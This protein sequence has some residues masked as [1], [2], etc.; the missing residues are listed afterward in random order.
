MARASGPPAGEPLPAATPPRRPGAPGRRSGPR[1]GAGVWLLPPWSRA[2]LL[3]FRAPAVIL[4][5]LGAAAIL[6]CASSSAGLF[7]SSAGAEALHRMAAADCPD[8]TYPTIQGYS[9]EQLTPSVQEQ[10]RGSM[11]G[12]GLPGPYQVLAP[13][14]PIRLTG[15]AASGSAPDAAVNVF[16]RQDAV[17][18]VR[19]LSRGPARGLWLPDSLASSLGVRAGQQLRL[20]KASTIPVAGVYRELSREPVQ[21]YWCSYATLFANTG[22]SIVL[23]PLVLATDIGTVNAVQRAQL[24]G[25]TNYWVSPIDPTRLTL[26]SARALNDKQAAAYRAFGSSP[27]DDLASRLS[28]TGQLPVFT[29][30]AGLIRSGLRAPV[31][32]IALGGTLLALLLIGAAGS[33]WADRRAGEVRLLSAR[34]VG[35]AAL[36]GKAVAE[37]AA[38]AAVGTLLGWLAA[39]WLVRS[40]GPSRYVDPGAPARALLVAGAALVAGLALL[41]LVAGRRARAATEVTIGARRGRLAAVPWELA[42]L[43]AAGGCYLALRR[44]QAVVLT[45][46][47]A[48]VNLLVVTFPL[49][50]MAGSAVL[51][52]RLLVLALPAAL[53]RPARRWPAWY[54]AS[55]RVTAARL[56]TVILLAAATMPIAVG[57]YAAGLTQTTQYTLDSKAR[58]F[59]GGNSSINSVDPLRRT[60]ATDRAGTVVTRYQYASLDGQR[61]IVLAIDPDTFAA[62]TFW[63]RRYADQPLATLL[64]RLRQPSAGGR[65]P[66][67]VVAADAGHTPVQDDQ[68]RITLGHSTEQL[69]VA[70]VPRLFPGRRLPLPMLVVDA[71]RLGQVDPHAGTVNELWTRGPVDPAQAAVVAQGARIFDIADLVTV[72]NVANFLG[73]SWTFGYLSAL[74]ALVGLVAIGGLLLYLETRQRSRIAAYALGRR[75]GLT[76]ATHLRS[77]LAELGT[78]LI[79]ALVLGTGLA[80][81]AVLLVYRQLNVDPDRPPAPLLTV[82]TAALIGAG[83]IVVVITALAAAYAQRAADRTNVAEVL[84]LGA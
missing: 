13:E 52:V 75:M 83:I 69:T 67:L 56:V 73:I 39:G 15:R 43:A 29:E 77:L 68:L 20:G 60:P 21:P 79:T 47:V 26:S 40:L 48:Q 54:L 41:A 2:P 64:D 59:V 12:A 27:P 81:A 14:S 7:L 22:G 24:Y 32:P 33:Y 11:T 55:R 70:G 45:R 66:A 10:G 9:E 8:A 78:L 71:A 65:V 84:R 19:V 3:A 57:V 1:R 38:P 80:A 50:F 6:A 25:M 49:L 16:Y 76:R 4:A 36:A 31:L 82:P 74:A 72:F 62:T 5:V 42:L 58:L 35:P 63:D 53:R 30:Q 17:D 46:G 61:V 28:G 18:H 37:L 51:L 23:R 34:G 44:G